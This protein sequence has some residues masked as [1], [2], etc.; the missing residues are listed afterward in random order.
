[1]GG[2]D[3]TYFASLKKE[4][5]HDADDAT[6]GETR[7]SLFESIEVFYDRVRRTRRSGDRSPAEDERAG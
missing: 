7:A 6:R 3:I 1:M 5:V 4:L 2:R